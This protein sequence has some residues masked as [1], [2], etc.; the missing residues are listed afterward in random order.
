MSQ[1]GRFEPACNGITTAGGKIAV[2][3]LKVTNYHN[4]TK[5]PT[6]VLDRN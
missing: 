5:A 4:K 1:T 3:V 6:K 2:H